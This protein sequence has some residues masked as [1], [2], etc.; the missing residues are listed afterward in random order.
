MRTKYYSSELWIFIS[1]D[2]EWIREFEKKTLFEVVV[3]RYQDI[4]IGRYC[5]VSVADT[6]TPQNPTFRSQ[7]VFELNSL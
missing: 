3:D 4:G 2:P 6:D 7:T 5:M 1:R